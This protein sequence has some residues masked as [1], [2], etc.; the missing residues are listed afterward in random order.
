M[1][2][3]FVLQM[4]AKLRL[5]SSFA[6]RLRKQ[7]MYVC[8]NIYFFA[9]FLL[10]KCLQTITVLFQFLSLIIHFSQYM[11]LYALI[12]MNC[13][14]GYSL[15]YQSEFLHHLLHFPLSFICLT[16][17]QMI[18]NTIQ[19]ALIINC[20]TGIKRKDLTQVKRAQK[21]RYLCY[22]K[23]YTYFK[24]KSCTAL[25]KGLYFEKKNYFLQCRSKGLY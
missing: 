16:M 22:E 3:T 1:I 9:L 7:L 14:R 25:L 23:I 21:A 20:K 13:S 15:S 12:C 19:L 6:F 5:A 4:S 18:E 17:Y 24:Y 11:L 8:K 10:C 2:C